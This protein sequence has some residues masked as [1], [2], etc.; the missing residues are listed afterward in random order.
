MNEWTMAMKT[1]QAKH[2]TAIQKYPNGKHGLVGSIPIELTEPSPSLYSPN[3]RDSMVW[4]TEE[5]VIEALLSIGVSRFQR[6]DC[7]WYQASL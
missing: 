1:I 4:N 2:S 6:V 7:S 3:S 5:E